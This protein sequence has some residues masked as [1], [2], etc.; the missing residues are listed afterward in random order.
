MVYALSTPSG[1]V[2]IL[3]SSMKGTTAIVFDSKE[4]I[5]RRVT[6]CESYLDPFDMLLISY[7][8]VMPPCVPHWV[9][10]T[11]NAICVGRHFY[12]SSSIRSS[13]IG[14]VHTFL[15]RGVITN[16]DHL[17]TRTLLYQLMTFWFLRQDK[18]EADGEVY[19]INA[20][21]LVLIQLCL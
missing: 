5:C 15:L 6:C 10:G 2:G 20:L 3:T 4:S 7:S 9:L 16:E 17:N 11:S 18:P 8:S 12:S 1:L 14:I 21:T 13:V 19:P